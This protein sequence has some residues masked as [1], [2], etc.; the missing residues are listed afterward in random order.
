M[1]KANRPDWITELRCGDI[2]ATTPKVVDDHIDY[3]VAPSYLAA[4]PGEQDGV[5][6]EQAREQRCVTEQAGIFQHCLQL[7]W[8]LGTGRHERH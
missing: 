1:I 3:G 6:V 4:R 5:V 8:R 2:T 7:L